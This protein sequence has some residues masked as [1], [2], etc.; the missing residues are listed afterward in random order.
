MGSNPT[1]TA[2]NEI[3]PLMGGFIYLGDVVGIWE[4]LA[5]ASDGSHRYRHAKPASCG[6][7]FC[8]AGYF[9]LRDLGAKA[10]P[11]WFPPIPDDAS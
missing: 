5:S 9:G 10:K 1:D 3:P 11:S 4:E 8:V 6:Q 7:V 2:I